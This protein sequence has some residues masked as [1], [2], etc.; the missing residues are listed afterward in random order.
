MALF[1]TKKVADITDVSY[2]CPFIFSIAVSQM[3]MQYISMALRAVSSILPQHEMW[4]CPLKMH[5]SNGQKSLKPSP[6]GESSL[7]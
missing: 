5:R 7:P 3:G 4:I 2:V 6:K 1:K